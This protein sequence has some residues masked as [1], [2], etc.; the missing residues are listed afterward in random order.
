MTRRIAE[1]SNANP[2]NDR[3]RVLF[4]LVNDLLKKVKLKI[5]FKTLISIFI[6]QHLIRLL[7]D[8]LLTEIMYK[9]WLTYLVSVKWLKLYKKSYEYVK[10]FNLFS[11][12]FI[13]FYLRKVHDLFL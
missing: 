9:N 1:S 3:K 12:F 2:I 7:N 6:Y 8:G 13:V 4:L 5:R 10:Y 11:T